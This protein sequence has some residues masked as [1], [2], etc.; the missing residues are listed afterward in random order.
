MAR[1]PLS[2]APIAAALVLLLAACVPPPSPAPPPPAPAPAPAATQAPVAPPPA[3]PVSGQVDLMDAR[4]LAG[5]WRWRTA[6]G[7]SIAE[8]AD[9]GGQPRVRLTCAADRSIVLAVTNRHRGATSLL[10]RTEMMERQVAVTEHDGWVEARLPAR[11]NLLD[12]IAFSR[13]RFGLEIDG[14][15]A[16]YVAPYPELTRVIEDCR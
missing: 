4:P 2:A 9:S 10:V 5:D 11:D 13:G 15:D 8:F 3:P 16:L 7:E 1:L 6:G 12:A 14:G